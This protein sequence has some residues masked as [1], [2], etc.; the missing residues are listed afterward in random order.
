MER[1]QKTKL[2]IE[3]ASNGVIVRNENGETTL[4]LAKYTK[5]TEGYGYDADRTAEHQLIGHR[6]SDWLRE[7]ADFGDNYFN[8]D[9]EITAR[10]KHPVE[11][12]EE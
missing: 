5:R 7:E 12:S 11:P 4:A 3:F 10:P 9:I 8:F 2:S 1:I 6:I